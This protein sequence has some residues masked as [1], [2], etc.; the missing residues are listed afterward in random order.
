MR[1]NQE[2]KA[3]YPEYLGLSPTKNKNKLTKVLFLGDKQ[4]FRYRFQTTNNRNL[5][6]Q[7]IVY[8]HKTR[9][10]TKHRR[11]VSFFV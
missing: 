8:I 3:K 1:I 10:A 5:L 9:N 2:I 11:T 4:V 6:A 7:L